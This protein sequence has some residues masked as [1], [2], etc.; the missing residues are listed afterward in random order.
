MISPKS[1]SMNGTIQPPWS[2]PLLVSSSAPPGPCIT[3]SIVTN[4]VT[5]S[6]IARCLLLSGRTWMR[7]S[8]GLA[9]TKAPRCGTWITSDAA[10]AGIGGDRWLDHKTSSLERDDPYVDPCGWRLVRPPA[11]QRPW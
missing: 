4:V 8:S 9:A 10:A 5:I 1:W 7:I 6:S 11:R 2:N 3:P